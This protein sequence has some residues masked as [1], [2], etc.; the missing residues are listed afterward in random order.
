MLLSEAQRRARAFVDAIGPHCERVEVAG[1]VRRERPEVGDIEIVCIPRKV[2]GGLFGDMEDVDPMFVSAV[3]RFEGL[4]G[5]PKGKYTRRVLSEGVEV[6]LF[7]C[8]EDNWGLNFAIRTGSRDF[9][10][11]ELAA[12]WSRMGYRSEGAILRR[13]GASFPLRE[14]ADVF[15][16][17]G[18]EWV[19]P[20]D[21]I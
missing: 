4:K 17:L 5:G 15:D 10:A 13:D 7:I 8:T 11:G 18:M 21:R 3:E 20:R 12:R 19:E 16:F 14:E 9:V 6:D 1:S 2:A